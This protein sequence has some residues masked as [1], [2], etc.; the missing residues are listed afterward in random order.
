MTDGINKRFVRIFYPINEQPGPKTANPG[1]N[2][3]SR[4]DLNSA[5]IGIGRMF[6][7]EPTIRKIGIIK[8]LSCSFRFHLGN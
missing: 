6:L 8:N 4:L 2:S 1:L 3:E 5:G 7:K